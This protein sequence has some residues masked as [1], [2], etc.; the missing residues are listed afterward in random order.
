MP[1][2]VLLNV[3][4][5]LLAPKINLITSPYLGNMYLD[6][7]T[8]AMIPLFY[9]DLTNLQSNQQKIKIDDYISL[10]KYPIV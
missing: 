5:A 2:G 6:S 10:G 4:Q 3:V 1:K 7:K 9:H 8:Y